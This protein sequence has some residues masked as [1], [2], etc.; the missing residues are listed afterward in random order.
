MYVSFFF[1]SSSLSFS[2]SHSSSIACDYIKVKSIKIKFSFS[3]AKK[4]CPCTKII[5]TFFSFL[6]AH[7]YK[8]NQRLASNLN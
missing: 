3:L 4:G 2:L 6:S 1:S 7:V 5:S 8:E